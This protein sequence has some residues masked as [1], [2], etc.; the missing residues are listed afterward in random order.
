M[1]TDDPLPWTYL[2]L[3]GA[4]VE[5]IDQAHSLAIASRKTRQTLVDHARKQLAA[6]PG[7]GERSLEFDE[8]IWRAIGPRSWSRS[9]TH[10]KSS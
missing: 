3:A 2:S 6:K 10:S 1:D 9:V 4:H 8:P 7:S 5:F